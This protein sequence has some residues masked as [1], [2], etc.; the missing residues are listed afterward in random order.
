MNGDSQPSGE[1]SHELT[2]KTALAG[3]GVHDA[4]PESGDNGSEIGSNGTGALARLGTWQV[5]VLAL[6]MLGGGGFMV[7]VGTLPVWAFL[8][9]AGAYFLGVGA[10]VK[11]LDALA[12]LR[13]HVSTSIADAV[14][15]HH[16]TTNA[17]LENA[18]AETRQ[19]VQAN[20]AAVTQVCGKLFSELAEN[21]GLTQNAVDRLAQIQKGRKR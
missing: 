10:V 18:K 7:H 8:V 6:V 5:F 9:A 2:A 19:T 1:S 14:A 15:A 3:G 17:A 12:D 4:A 20:T 21:T 13:A 16:E 11:L